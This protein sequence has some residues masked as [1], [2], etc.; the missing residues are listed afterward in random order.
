MPTVIPIDRLV[1]PTASEFDRHASG[2]KPF[3]VERATEHWKALDAW[4]P[5]YLMARAGTAPVPVLKVAEGSPDGKFFYGGDGLGMVTFADCLPLLQGLPPRV[6][7]AGVPISEYLPMLADDLGPLDFIAQKRQG[8]R[9]IWLSGRN[10]RGPLHYDLDDNI[11]VVIAGRKRF[12]LFDYAQTPDLYP[13]PAFSTTPNYC[14]VDAHDPDL[15]QFPRFQH[16]KGYDVTLERGQ[17]IYIPQGCWHQVITEVPSVAINF[18]LGKRYFRRS[19][20]RIVMNLSVRISAELAA[21]P[22]RAIA[23]SARRRSATPH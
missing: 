1:H 21:A 23:G 6:Y 16:A 20:W 15:G 14:R 17:M 13:C 9:Q 8:Q 4:T 10:S 19:M 3:V 11:H 12:L 2:M 7:M 22:W 18:W 5:D